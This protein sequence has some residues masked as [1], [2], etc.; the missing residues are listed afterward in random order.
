MVLVVGTVPD[1]DIDGT[2]DTRRTHRDHR[3]LCT[4]QE[5]EATMKKAH[6]ILNTA[7]FITLILL[8]I[9]AL[10]CGPDLLGV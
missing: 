10:I 5:V 1:M 6:L 3:Y 9:V 7:I 8:L 4:R 2:D